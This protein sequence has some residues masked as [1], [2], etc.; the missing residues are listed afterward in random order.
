M[1]QDKLIKKLKHQLIVSC[2]AL[3]GEPLYKEEGGIMSLMAKAAENAGAKG[4]RAQGITDIR[5]IQKAVN[6]PIIGIIKKDYSD[7]EVYITPT[8]DEIDALVKAEVDIIALDATKR[9]RPKEKTLGKF[10]KEIRKKYGDILLMAD[11]STLEEG[12]AAENAGFDL[13]GT[14]L[15][16]Y[17]PYS[18]K[19]DEPNYD[20][21]KKLRKNIKI[22]VIAEG[23]IHTPKQAKKVFDYGAYA[24]VVGGAIT[25]PEE[26]AGRFMEKIKKV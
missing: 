10:L 24:V 11:I 20:L 1:K 3:P 13:V 6:L 15:A 8:M 4:I 22:P 12:I 5:Q 9:P 18:E 26:I 2:Q 21:I 23:K 7:S 16:G 17:T 19:R 14:T 25:R